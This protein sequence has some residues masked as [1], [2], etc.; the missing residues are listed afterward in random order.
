MHTLRE[1]VSA[2]L[3]G[4]R[5]SKLARAAQQAWDEINQ[6]A[7]WYEGRRMQGDEA[8]LQAGARRFALDV[9]RALQIALACEHAQ[10]AADENG[11]R[12]PTDAARYLAAGSD[13]LLRLKPGPTRR[14]ALDLAT[15]EDPD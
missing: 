3:A 10:W 7:D 12:R 4:C 1:L 8:G 9:G 15:H 2:A 5:K 13:P 6:A 11:D 14:L